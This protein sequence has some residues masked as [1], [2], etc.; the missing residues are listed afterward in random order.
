MDTDRLIVWNMEAIANSGHPEALELF[1][2]IILASSSIP[3]TFPPVLINVRLMVY[4]MM[5]C[6]SMAGLRYSY[7]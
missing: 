6:M 1:R 2:K 7:F 3:L 4:P 5:R